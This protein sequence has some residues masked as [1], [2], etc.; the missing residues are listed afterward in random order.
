M[1]G[2][3]QVGRKFKKARVTL[4]NQYRVHDRVATDL[5][6]NSMVEIITIKD[7][8]GDQTNVA[9]SLRDDPLG[10]LWAR[11]QI[12][13][14]KYQAGRKWQSDYEAAEIGAVGAI[15]TTKEPVDG[16]K[17]PDLV[18][19]KQRKAI[20]AISDA[21]AV[22]GIEG[23]A[24]IRDILGK[25]MWMEQVAASRGFHNQR[26]VDYFARRFRECLETLALFYGYA[27]KYGRPNANIRSWRA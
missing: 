6:I 26:T 8:A 16:R 23:D 9:M 17:F 19:D 10:R 1:H 15:D 21:G 11:Q 3:L 24:L 22:L 20:K 4:A 27:Q 14:A 12:D 5:T 25:R 7:P 18:T 13:D 2:D